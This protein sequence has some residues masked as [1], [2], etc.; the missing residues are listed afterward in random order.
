MKRFLQRFA[1]LVRRHLAEPEARLACAIPA[2]KCSKAGW[3]W[4]P[5]FPGFAASVRIGNATVVEGDEGRSFAE[6]DVFFTAGRGGGGT[7]TVEYTTADGT[8]T[9]ADDDYRAK[10]GTLRFANGK[11]TKSIRVPVLGDRDVEAN[12]TFFVNLS[13]ATGGGSRGCGGGRITDRQGIGVIQDDDFAK[14]R[15]DDFNDG[16][17]AGW[18]HLDFTAGQPWGPATYDASSG[19]IYAAI[20]GGCPEGRPVGGNDCR[21]LGGLARQRVVWPRRRARDRASQ[22]AGLHSRFAASGQ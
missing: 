21:D 16:D 11:T 22:Y 1:N 9:R 17:D 14:R 6:F 19:R 20:G 10:S 2:W 4:P 8:A 12:E 5:C 3:R 13:N 7:R 18:S 15:I